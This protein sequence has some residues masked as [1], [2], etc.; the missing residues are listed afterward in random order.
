M[1]TQVLGAQ[2][3]D[4][5]IVQLGTQ[6]VTPDQARDWLATSLMNRRLNEKMVERLA[7]DIVEG[8]WVLNGESIKFDR[9]GHLID[10][11]HRLSAIAKSGQPV[12]VV[13]VRNLSDFAQQTIDIGVARTVGQIASMAGVSRANAKAAIAVALIRYARHRDVKWTSSNLPSK[14]EQLNFVL[15]NDAS[16]ATCLADSEAAHRMMGANRSAYAAGSY[17]IQGSAETS[18]WGEFHNR[19]V[20]GARLS[21]GDPRLAF[22]NQVMR[23]SN[24]HGI[25]HMQQ[26]MAWLLKAWNAYK[27]GQSVKV[28]RF[29]DSMLPM[30][31]V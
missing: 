19:I 29:T 11:Q 9:S 6:V 16:L 15:L 20:D 3:S 21:H 8:R 22:R 1:S 30:P 13:V 5:A 2:L 27:T 7:R 25:W 28:L 26:E 24:K 17:L 4:E 10:G 18:Q 23:R 31:E 12:P 14:T